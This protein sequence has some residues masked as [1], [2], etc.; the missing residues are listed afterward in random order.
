MQRSRNSLILRKDDYQVILS[1]LRT[2]PHKYSFDRKNAEA[3]KIELKKAKLVSPDKF[4]ADAVRLNSKV[5]V[6]E[7]QND[8]ILEF[9]LVTP[10]KADIKERK[11]SVMAPI[12][13]AL[14]GFR[15]GQ[16]VN[17]QVPSGKKTFTIMEVSNHYD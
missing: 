9:I 7:D 15:E 8:Q 10:D 5:K 16:K 14:I 6:K 13:T 2:G 3:L 4:P 17:W 11:I 1:C 12:G